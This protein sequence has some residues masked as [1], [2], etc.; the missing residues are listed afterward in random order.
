MPRP[1]PPLN[2]SRTG[3]IVVFVSIEPGQPSAASQAD[4][5]VIW[6][7]TA[8]LLAMASLGRMAMGAEGCQA[9]LA[10]PFDMVGPFDLGELERLGRIEFAACVVMSRQRWQADQA[11]LRQAALHARQATQAR[12]N[13]SQRARFE[14]GAGQGGDVPWRPGEERTHREALELPA[15]GA[16]TP[17]LIKAAFRR[18]A[19]KL[20]P[21][22][23]GTHA[24]FVRITQARRALLGK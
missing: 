5:W 19:Q 4:E 21:D 9:W 16:L 8:G 20:H 18:L 24:Q 10:P 15:E 3:R 17:A 14:S 7:G 2:P 13:A 12:F 6:N 23:G 22:V 1:Q 11:V